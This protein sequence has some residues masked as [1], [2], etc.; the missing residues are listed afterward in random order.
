MS[1]STCHFKKEVNPRPILP[2]C[3]DDMDCSNF[4]LESHRGRFYHT[5]F[6]DNHQK[7]MEFL[8][9][10]GKFVLRE[11]EKNP[12]FSGKYLW[13]QFACDLEERRMYH[14]ISYCQKNGENKIDISLLEKASMKM[15]MKMKK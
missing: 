13:E 1:N 5:A 6:G 8:L 2:L 7:R 12:N 4:D 10:S 14:F 11:E 9:K 15:K 3:R